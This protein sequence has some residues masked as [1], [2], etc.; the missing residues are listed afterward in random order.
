MKTL[1]EKLQIIKS[2][3]RENHIKVMILGL[4][5][6]GTYLLDYLVSRN[7]PAITLIVVG[8][9]LEKIESDVNIVKVA[10]L[11]RHQNCSKILI[12]G[13]VDFTDEEKIVG[14][15]R[16]HNP[17][18]IIN[19]SRVYPGLKYGSISWNNIRAYG[20]WSPLA[21]DYI[22]HIMKACEAAESHGIVINTSYSDVII[23]WLK[24]GG[25]AYPDFGSG[26]MNHLIPRIKYAVA[27]YLKVEDFW[28]IEVMFATG[29][30]H[31][32]VIS[33]EGHT[34]GIE[35][36]IQVYY[37]DHEL[38]IPQ[39]EIFSRCKISMPVDA[40]RNMMN[41]S[42]NYE[43][44]AA[45]I[46]ALRLGEKRRFY[47]PGVFGEIGGYPVIIDGMTEVPQAY[48]DE[49]V[50]TLAQMREKN[51]VSI[52]LDGIERVESGNLYY[53]DELIEKVKSVFHVTLQKA[54]SLEDS[55]VTA[56]RIIKD[57]IVK[58]IS[59]G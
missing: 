54:V 35:Q 47:S 26:N 27:E 10:A 52:Y 23:P 48:I 11:I 33:K 36:L 30:F 42:S 41:A 43:I 7:D 2:S 49:T 17:D 12:E 15:I 20:I 13:D 16:K 45:I 6:V 22:K 56:E 8:R 51:R 24:S 14:C 44:I 39:A 18:F 32:I 31:D 28:N 21:A 58:N 50:F 59:K 38:Q 46:D 3:I 40:K 25:G 19:S 29:H 34:E 4:G 1:Q 57:I 37:K 9:N 55:H 5:S 53:T